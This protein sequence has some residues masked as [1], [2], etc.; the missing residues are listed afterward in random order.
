M[1]WHNRV[2]NEL[3]STPPWGNSYLSHDCIDECYCDWEQVSNEYTPVITL[4]KTQKLEALNMEYQTK[5]DNLS[6]RYAKITLSD[7]ETV[8]VAQAALATEYKTLVT[9]KSTKRGAILND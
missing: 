8:A 3:S 4:T 6:A 1:L 2:T 5:F 9:E 7:G